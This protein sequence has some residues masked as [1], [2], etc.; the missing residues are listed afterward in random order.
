MPTH[1]IS[2]S[3]QEAAKIVAAIIEKASVD[4]GAPVA[5]AVVDYAGRLVAF[6]AMDNVMPASI[7]LVQSKAYSAVIGKKDT[8]QWASTKKNS[9]YIDFDMR[10]WTDE[11]FTCFTGGVVIEFEGQIIGGIAV[12]GRKGKMGDGDALIQDNELAGYGKLI[13]ERLV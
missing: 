7:K 10:N 13:F 4:G 2:I 9:E 11:N 6:T 1:I 8:I 12:S 5:V 3:H